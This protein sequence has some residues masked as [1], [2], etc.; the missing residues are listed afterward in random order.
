VGFTR[1]GAAGMGPLITL[2]PLNMTLIAVLIVASA[3][4]GV[5]GW[6]YSPR[7]GRLVS[8]ALLLLL[9]LAIF[10]AVS[11]LIRIYIFPLPPF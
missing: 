9:S 4:A 5:V 7:M 2:S 11:V 3:V 1:K 8:F 10:V 6:R